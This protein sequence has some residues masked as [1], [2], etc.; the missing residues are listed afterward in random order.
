MKKKIP[1]NVNIGVDIEDVSRFGKLDRITDNIFLSKIFTENELKYCFS[2][3]NRAEHLAGR[4][5]AKESVIKALYA[6]DAPVVSYSE[7]EIINDTR[8]LPKVNIY[9]QRCK[10]YTIK[11]SISHS[12]TK[13]LTAA[14]AQQK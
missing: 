11:V 8:G 12:K 3:K 7:I 6:F 2:K 10:V 5:S 9:N 13:V 14:I 1:K 4:F